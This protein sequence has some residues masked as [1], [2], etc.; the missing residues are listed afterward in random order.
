MRGKVAT[1]ILFM[2]AALVGGSAC[3]MTSPNPG[4]R[5]QVV[6]GSHLPADTGGADALC[7]AVEQALQAAQPKPAAVEVNVV[8]PYLLSATV[9]LADGRKLPEIKVG[10]SDRQLGARTV[11]M[12]ADSI[13]AQVAA[14]QSK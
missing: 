1:A 13:A 9:M 10:S 2:T 5:C 14:Q 12:L 11:R 3:A 7:A 8:S 4:S 6:G